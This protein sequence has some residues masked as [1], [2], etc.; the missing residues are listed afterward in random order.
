[1]A[2][3]TYLFAF[4]L[5]EGAIPYIYLDDIAAYRLGLPESGREK[6]MTL[7]IATLFTALTSKPA[8]FQ[9]F[10]VEMWHAEAWKGLPKG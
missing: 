6:G 4:P 8:K 10:L 5:P 9:A 7:D 3:D 2:G 1:M